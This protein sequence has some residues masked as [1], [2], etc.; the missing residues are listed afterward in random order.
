[1]AKARPRERRALVKQAGQLVRQIHEAGYHLP[2]GDAWARRL[3]VVRDTGAVL[4]ARLEPLERTN[5]A[6]Q[7]I[8]PLEFSR[9]RLRLT[10]S[11]QLRFLRTYL[12]MD[13]NP[14]TLQ[15]FVP[16]KWITERQR[17]A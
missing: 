4:L 13:A 12:G 10:R 15:L 2:P 6:W 17:A 3:G 7:E 14:S 8:A 11:E 9:E 1:Y 5:A 16:R